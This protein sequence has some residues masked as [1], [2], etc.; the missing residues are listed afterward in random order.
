MVLRFAYEKLVP[1]LTKIFPLAM[2]QNLDAFV[3]FTSMLQRY[4]NFLIYASFLA[5]IFLFDASFY[6]DK[7]NIQIFIYS[8]T[9]GTFCELHDID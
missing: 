5:I 1:W 9:T 2:P 3:C 6:I 4:E 8:N 7:A